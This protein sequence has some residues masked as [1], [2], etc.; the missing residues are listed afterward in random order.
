MSHT[1]WLKVL[2]NEV[3]SE[4]EDIN[5]EEEKDSE[6]LVV[7]GDNDHAPVI[8]IYELHMNSEFTEI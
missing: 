8:N 4:D 7:D 2:G 6:I 5:H 3:I 1:R